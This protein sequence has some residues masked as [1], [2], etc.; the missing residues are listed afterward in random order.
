MCSL[1]VLRYHL[2]PLNRTTAASVLTRRLTHAGCE[3]LLSAA[4][5]GVG[6]TRVLA[7]LAAQEG[8]PTESVAS[9]RD[10]MGRTAT[11]LAVR[12][13][14]LTQGRWEGCLPL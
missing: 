8:T 6:L 2:S 10:V 11:V 3:Q 7:Q 12:S 1:P 13:F 5:S 14:L 9:C 4:A